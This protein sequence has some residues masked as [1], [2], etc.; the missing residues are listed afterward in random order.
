MKTLF[1]VIAA[2]ALLASSSPA[3]DPAVPAPATAATPVAATDP[4]AAPKSPLQFLQTMKA[5]N[6]ALIERQNALLLKLEELHK[7]ASQIKFL[8]KR[9]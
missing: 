8:S 3:Q 4:A 6:A 2:I 1:L 9:G 7:E 5:Q